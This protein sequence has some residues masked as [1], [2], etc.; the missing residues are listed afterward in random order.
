MTSTALSQRLDTW[1]KQHSGTRSELARKLSK[2]LGDKDA[3]TLWSLVNIRAEFASRRSDDYR[4]N[5]LNDGP[6]A[7]SLPTR[8][9][10]YCN[11]LLV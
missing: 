8:A 10:T 11:S 5:W 3:G 1:A 4:A 2:D 6:L 7:R 9:K